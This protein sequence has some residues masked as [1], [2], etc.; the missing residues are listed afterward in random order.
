M[1]GRIIL[2]THPVYPNSFKQRLCSISDTAWKALRDEMSANMVSPV[3]C[4][5]LY[6]TFPPP[7]RLRSEIFFFYS[8]TYLTF[9]ITTS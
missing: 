2:L 1:G 9:D 5:Y 6:V 7:Q 3:L 4:L 8:P